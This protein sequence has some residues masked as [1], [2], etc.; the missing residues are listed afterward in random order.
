MFTTDAI[1]QAVGRAVVRSS[2]DPCLF[3]S[4]G[5]G[6]NDVQLGPAFNTVFQGPKGPSNYQ[7]CPS[8]GDKNACYQS[9]SD[10]EQERVVWH[11]Q[12]F[13]VTLVGPQDPGAL[14]QV[15]STVLKSMQKVVDA[16]S[17]Q[18]QA[19]GAGA[20]RADAAMQ[21]KVIHVF[22]RIRSCAKQQMSQYPEFSLEDA[23]G[24]CSGIARTAGGPRM[25]ASYGSGVD[26]TLTGVSTSETKFTIAMGD[27]GVQKRT[28]SPA[29]AGACHGDRSW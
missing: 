1:G 7:P 23:L 19:G 11:Q 13:V 16:A 20:T 5:D 22:S 9:G 14:S 8:L 29:G 15:S 21:Q 28:C 24:E 27:N 18:P 6:S 25:Q 12:S 26:F 17:A 2:V 3:Q 10:T 4:H